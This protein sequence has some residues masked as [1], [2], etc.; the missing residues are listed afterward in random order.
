MAYHT[1]RKKN[2]KSLKK[3]EK[4]WCHR[5][6]INIKPHFFAQYR[7]RRYRGFTL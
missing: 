3:H 1:F 7:I 5:V 2:R 4:N 6:Q